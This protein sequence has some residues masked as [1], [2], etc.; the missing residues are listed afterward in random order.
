MEERDPWAMN[1][2]SAPSSAS[3]GLAMLI[4]NELPSDVDHSSSPALPLETPFANKRTPEAPAAKTSDHLASTSMDIG[5]RLLQQAI[6]GRGGR[7]WHLEM[8][9]VSCESSVSVDLSLGQ[10]P[11]FLDDICERFWFPS[12]VF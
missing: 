11:S 3:V 8:S 12:F 1:I 5:L 2:L 6:N 7:F 4:G 9:H 10:T